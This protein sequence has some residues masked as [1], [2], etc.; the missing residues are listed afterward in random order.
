M[1][2]DPINVVYKLLGPSYSFGLSTLQSVQSTTSAL[3]PAVFG[4]QYG[5]RRPPSPSPAA[6]TGLKQEGP[7]PSRGAVGALIRTPLLVAV[8]LFVLELLLLLAIAIGQLLPTVGLLLV[9]RWLLLLS[10]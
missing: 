7:L 2:M 6:A 9:V 10:Y 3:L 1:K 8:L 4:G 5:D